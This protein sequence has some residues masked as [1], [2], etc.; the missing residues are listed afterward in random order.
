MLLG[1][2]PLECFFEV[3][4]NSFS[5]ISSSL[6]DSKVADD[7][8]LV[9]PEGPDAS[10]LDPNFDLHLDF[11]LSGGATIGTVR[12][13]TGGT[14]SNDTIDAE[15]SSRVWLEAGLPTRSGEKGAWDF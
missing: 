5:E 4:V 12:L 8:E 10:F 13:L 7:S 3:L 2:F 11:P 9:S 6:W 15:G 14:G 1:P